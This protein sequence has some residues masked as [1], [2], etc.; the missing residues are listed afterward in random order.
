MH[1]LYRQDYL[2]VT[3]DEAH[4]FRNYGAKHSAALTILRKSIVRLILTATPLQTAT[5]VSKTAKAINFMS[6]IFVGSRFD[7]PFNWHSSF[8]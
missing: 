7:G 4:H 2:S 1:T 3:L 8:P 6:D 5:T